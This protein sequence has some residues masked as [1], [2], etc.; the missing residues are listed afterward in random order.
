MVGKLVPGASVEWH[1][2][3]T[4]AVLSAA[5]HCDSIAFRFVPG[6]FVFTSRDLKHIDLRVKP[7]R[8]S[9]FLP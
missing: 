9:R 2:K 6:R 3:A 1:A 4:Q 7:K 8:L 5:N